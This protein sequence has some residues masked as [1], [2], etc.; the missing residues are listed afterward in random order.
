M[1]I[2]II[3]NFFIYSFGTLLMRGI[4]L[5]LAPL[6]LSVLPPDQYG[7]LSL[8]TSFITILSML[9]GLGLRQSFAL[10]YFQATSSERRIIVNHLIVTYL[11][12]SLPVLL[13]LLFFNRAI[14]KFYFAGYASPVLIILALITCFSYFFVELYYQILRYQCKALRVTLTQVSIALL[15]IILNILFIWYLRLSITSVI[16]TQCL[17]TFIICLLAGWQYI[18]HRCL[19]HLNIKQS[20]GCIPQYVVRGLPFIPNLLVSW[21]LAAGDRWLLAQFGTMQE[22][23]VYS[24]ASMFGQLFEML[25]LYPLTGSY[26]PYLLNRFAQEKENIKTI[27]YQNKKI[28]WWVMLSAFLLITVGCTIMRPILFWLLPISYQPAIQYVW[29]LLIG[30]IF[31]LGTYFTNAIQ[32]HLKKR[33]FFAYAMMIPT[34]LN[35]LLNILLIPLLN[36]WGCVIATTVSYAIYFGICLWFNHSAMEIFD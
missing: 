24:L 22:V 2:S 8:T 19:P 32:Q 17:G 11:I 12:I 29:L 21:F 25:I 13:L 28:M 4:S 15:T 35:I 14:N 18:R 36:I 3:K 16:A 30:Y 7:L 31:L 33:S 5:L 10:E 23:G 27:E 9:I 34:L 6:L 26:L 20:I 1:H